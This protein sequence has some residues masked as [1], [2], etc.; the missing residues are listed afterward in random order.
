[1]KAK[2]REPSCKP[3]R[4]RKPRLVAAAPCPEIQDGK[5]CG[6]P[7]VA[8]DKCWRHLQRFYRHGNTKTVLKPGVKVNA[9]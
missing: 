5:T 6:G 9:K 1:M 8:R 4:R 7:V 3:K 2:T